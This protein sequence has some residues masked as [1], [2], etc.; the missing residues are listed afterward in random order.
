[1][2]EE[3]SL[4][5]D[6]ATDDGRERGVGLTQ[7]SAWVVLHEVDLALELMALL[8]SSKGPPRCRFTAPMPASMPHLQPRIIGQWIG[9]SGWRR[10]DDA[11]TIS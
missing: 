4:E 8:S 1:M 3:M 11:L 7:E 5:L 9:G 6:Q 2:L 10:D